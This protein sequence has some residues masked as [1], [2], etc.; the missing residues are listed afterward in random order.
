[1]IFYRQNLSIFGLT[2]IENNKI[3][4]V[5]PLKGGVSCEVYR[6][7]TKY[8][9]YCV[10]KALKK[11]KVKKNWY[12]DPI[13]SYYEYLWL[14][15]AKKILPDSIPEVLHFNK[16][17][18]FLIIEYLDM[19][20]FTNLKDD[21]LKGNVNIPVISSLSKNYVLFMQALNLLIIK[22]FFNLTILTLL[23]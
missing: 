7:D 22:K 1:M 16:K 21:L 9:S 14:K 15:K 19:K 6:V 12:A 23:I 18:N 10:K 11:L 2:K 3:V 4:S 8:K 20:K 17:H 5:T 13:R